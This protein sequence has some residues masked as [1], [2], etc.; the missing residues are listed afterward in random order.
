MYDNTEVCVECEYYGM[1]K[2][3]PKDC[4][5]CTGIHNVCSNMADCMQNTEKGCFSLDRK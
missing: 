2:E 5:A 3:R 4:N 1:N